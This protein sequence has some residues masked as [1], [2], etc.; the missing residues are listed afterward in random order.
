MNAT[1]RKSGVRA[2]VLG[3]NSL[4]GEAMPVSSNKSS[5]LRATGSAALARLALATIGALAASA[6]P[7]SAHYKVLYAF[8]SQQNCADGQQPSA[9]AADASGNLF[10]TTNVG[11]A[12]GFGVAFELKRRDNGRYKYEVL[13]SFCA[14]QCRDGGLPEAPVI[15]DVHGNLYGTTVLGGKVAAGIIYELRRRNGVWSI[16]TLHSFCSANVSP[17]QASGKN[18]PPKGDCPDGFAPVAGLTYAGAA[19]G[20]LYDGT[21]PLYGTMSNGGNKHG[22]A[23]QLTPG[24][25]GWTYQAIYNFCSV[26]NCTDGSYPFGSLLVDGT[27]NLY[28]V[29][30]TGG[31]KGQGAAFELSPSGGAW[32]ETVLYS[33]CRQ[34]S[35][36]DGAEPYGGLVMDAAGNLFGTTPIGG[37]ACPVEYYG[38]CGVAFKLVPDEPSARETV[39]HAFCAKANCADGAVPDAAP[40]IAANGDLFGT[41]RYGGDASGNGVVWRYSGSRYETVHTFCANG[42]C[43]KGSIP[44]AGVIS[45]KAGNLYGTTYGGGPNDGGVV[46]EITP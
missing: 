15:V 37:N 10:G 43:S 33:F 34:A 11:G 1:W 38:S 6:A 39:L 26:K 9:L 30:Q 41:T 24:D 4:R 22:L 31:S 18:R 32:N 23:Y 42:D 25:T 19:S 2:I 14:R 16:K 17:G 44:M 27:G 46:Y 29:T 35:C 45:D 40:V 21:S 28:G 36:A 13:Y 12:N 7:V 3:R 20:A 8:C 5:A